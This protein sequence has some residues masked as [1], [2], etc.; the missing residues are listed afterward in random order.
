MNANTAKK[1][2]YIIASVFLILGIGF[3]IIGF[4]PQGYYIYK[5]A[6]DFQYVAIPG[7]FLI[8]LGVGF[9]WVGKNIAK[10]RSTQNT[11]LERKKKSNAE[12]TD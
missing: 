10:W 4:A 5:G 1:A 3:T 7:W 9:F 2:F 12:S 6:P 11:K 8:L